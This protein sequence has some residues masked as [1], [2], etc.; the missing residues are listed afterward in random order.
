[1]QQITTFIA[2]IADALEISSTVFFKMISDRCL[3]LL[4]QFNR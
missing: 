3:M 4:Q 2:Q 1:M